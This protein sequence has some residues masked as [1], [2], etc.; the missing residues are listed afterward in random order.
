MDAILLFEKETGKIQSVSPGFDIKYFLHTQTTPVKSFAPVINEAG[1]EIGVREIE[2]YDPLIKDF[3]RIKKDL[4]PTLDVAVLTTR[5]RE[6]LLE[7]E[8]LD[9]EYPSIPYN[10]I[11]NNGATISTVQMYQPPVAKTEKKGFNSAGN[12]IT[13]Q[14]T[15]KA[16]DEYVNSVILTQSEQNFNFD[17][18]RNPPDEETQEPGEINYSTL[19]IDLHENYKIVNNTLVKVEPTVE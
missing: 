19:V 3:I 8:V 13:E 9:F 6:E 18:H 7:L 2:V 10:L 11:D 5:T 17:S 16:F 12:M 15:R 14:K 4:D 1:E